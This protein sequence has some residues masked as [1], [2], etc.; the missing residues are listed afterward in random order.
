[1]RVTIEAHNS[2]SQMR[3]IAANRS[4][5]SE[6]GVQ[7]TSGEVLII[8]VKRI[9]GVANHWALAVFERLRLLSGAGENA[10]LVALTSNSW[11]LKM[12]VY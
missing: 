12:V 2:V 5:E 4:A 11:S 1:M 10:R 8:I 3:M 9:R 6:S 7:A